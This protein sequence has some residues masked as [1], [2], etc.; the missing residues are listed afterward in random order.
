ML[1]NAHGE[2]IRVGKLHGQGLDAR[3]RG[4]QMQTEELE[5]RIGALEKDLAGQATTIEQRRSQIRED[6]G[7]IKVGAHKD[8]DRFVDEVI[9]QLPSVILLGQARAT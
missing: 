6:V 3:R 8:L 2:G 7:A 9:R 5:R 1:D 4:I